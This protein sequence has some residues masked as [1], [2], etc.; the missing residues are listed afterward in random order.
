[1][2][3][4]R[5]R[6]IGNQENKWGKTLGTIVL[7]LIM[8]LP[9]DFLKN[10]TGIETKNDVPQLRPNITTCVPGIDPVNEPETINDYVPKTVVDIDGTP[11]PAPRPGLSTPSPSEAVIITD[12]SKVSPISQRVNL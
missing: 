7:S 3:T 5:E 9:L 10:D 11:A 12:S 6:Y 2:S 8:C 4:S 1:M